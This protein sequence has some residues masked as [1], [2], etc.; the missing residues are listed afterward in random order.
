MPAD[1]NAEMELVVERVRKLLALA[2]RNPNEAE[3]TAAAAKAQEL[4]A[5]YN[6]DMATVE[7]AE[8]A[9]GA[10]E[11]AK[12][13]GG[14]YHYERDL[15]AE[16]ARL[17]FCIH[18]STR[19]WMTRRPELR[20]PD[21]TLVR[22]AVR[23]LA[24]AH[25]VVGRKVNT[26]AT[27]ALAQYLL[28]TIERLCR[29]RLGHDNSQFFTSWAVSYREGMAERIMEKLAER[30]RHL[31][32]EEQKKAR[33]AAAE[34]RHAAMAGESSATALT[35]ASLEKSEKDANT[36]FIYG[37]GTSARWA[38]QRAER[39]RREEEAERAWAEWAVAHPEEAAKE[40][41]REAARVRRLRGPRYAGPS[42]REQRRYGG[43]FRA[44]YEK[45]AEVGLGPP[46][47]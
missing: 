40:A 21:G 17:N 4:L 25:R 18:F 39:A 26:A 41:R 24:F 38:A 46:G 5:S 33:K 12:V 14:M 32:N 31:L 3:A 15:W 37:D 27:R 35:L 1:Q 29:E 9:S 7:N 19:Q 47:G 34:A 16:V 22:R 44:G 23:Y 30:R 43:G 45:G 2:A 36:D 20:A 11:D 42:A 13:R 28:Q 10:R 8:G 6:L